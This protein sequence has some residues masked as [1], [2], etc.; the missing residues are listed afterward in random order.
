MLLLIKADEGGR[1]G[2]EGGAPSAKASIFLRQLT[3]FSISED[4]ILKISGLLIGASLDFLWC[5]LSKSHF[6]KVLRGAA[7][8]P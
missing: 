5:L 7:N 8:K 2:A 1:D 3:N 4:S 6:G